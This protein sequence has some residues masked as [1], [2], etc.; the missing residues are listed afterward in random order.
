MAAKWNCFKCKYKGKVLGSC[1]ICC[2]NPS[3]E[4]NI[5]QD[6]QGVNG[7][8]C[9]FPHNFD[10]VWIDNCDGFEPADVNVLTDESGGKDE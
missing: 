8:W 2:K 3:T 4:L 7:G 10:P 9:N 5:E 1:H 6:P